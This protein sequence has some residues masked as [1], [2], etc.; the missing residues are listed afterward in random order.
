MKAAISALAAAY[1][2]SSAYAGGQVPPVSV[3]PSPSATTPATST[4]SSPVQTTA[5]NG[6]VLTPALSGSPVYPR[7]EIR[8][9]AAQQ[10][11]QFTLL[12]LA[13]QAWQQESMYSP[14]SFYGVG[15]IHGVGRPQNSQG[16]NDFNFVNQCNGCQS[17]GYCTHN[18]V[19]F[20][21][22][23]RVYV[24]MYEQQFL[25]RVQQVANSY[26][27]SQKTQMLAAAA[28]MRWPY[29]DW[30]ANPPAGQN[31]FPA[32]V[33]SPQVSVN[34]PNGQI[35]VANPLY[36]YSFTDSSL[37]Y[38]SP[39]VNWGQTRRYPNSNSANGVSQN[40]QAISAFANSQFA[41][42]IRSQVYSLFTQCS[43]YL[44]FSNA[45]ASSSSSSCANSLEGIHNTIH[46]TT[47]GTGSGSVYGGSMTYSPLASFDPIFFLHHANV[48]RLFAMWQTVNPGQYGASQ[49]AV[50]Y[51]WTI[52]V[53][54]T[55][56]V[57]SP[58]TPFYR[59]SSNFWTTAQVQNWNTTFGYTYP[60]FVNSP[61]DR[62][63]INAYVNS[64]Y[65][66]NANAVAGSSK[67]SVD[68]HH[69]TIEDLHAAA[70]TG[71]MRRDAEL[72][73]ANGS[74]YEYAA[75][76]QAPRLALNGSYTIYLFKGEPACE[77]TTAWATDADFI[78]T[79]GVLA[80]LGHKEGVADII[81]SGSI[82]LTE[83]LAS[84]VV[85]DSDSSLNSMTPAEVS[86]YLKAHLVW[87]VVG[88]DGCS[89]DPAT[90]PGFTVSVVSST[91]TVPTC[92]TEL[93]QYSQFTTLVNVTAGVA[94]GL[95]ASSS[96][97]GL[98][99]KGTNTTAAQEAISSSDPAVAAQISVGA[100]VGLKVGDLLDLDLNLGVNAGV[101][102]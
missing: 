51:T 45:A 68:G 9:M 89:V 49:R 6:L 19:L 94:G 23:H 87:K 91:A 18:S 8:Q 25:A 35:T 39:F 54:T 11:N 55:Q 7:L 29:W 61:G 37:Q 20:P 79:V 42:S 32:Q 76:V 88:P 93:P 97:L 12:I 66:P 57:N 86:A 38:Y 31:T 73:A 64:L 82:P 48:D 56:G 69:D 24:A 46:V 30:A 40:G 4:F 44:Y 63:A 26:S 59:D 95:N 14:T 15:S 53:G 43:S 84:I 77:D 36:Q 71:L 2:I 81:I 102:I 101:S 34:G 3:T 10:P 33:A 21:A 85:D 92:A 41:S 99:Y 60:E 80:G 28:T 58:L 72:T 13:L 83:V 75:N 16:Q 65:G 50:D 96:L 47:G 98:T 67:R 52:N 27:G 22:W 1:F 78:G 62:N 100:N 70:A 5:V 90:I 74:T 17:D